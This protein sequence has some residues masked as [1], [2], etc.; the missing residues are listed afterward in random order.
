MKRLPFTLFTM[1]AL[2]V[3]LIVGL[4]AP[5]ARAAKP[6]PPDDSTPPGETVKLIF[7]HHST[8][9]N[10][11]SDPNNDQPYGGL[12]RA[13]MENNY[14][15]SATNYGWGPD[16][17]GD[18]TD[19]P[20]WPEWFTGPN[21]AAYLDALYNENGQNVGD[22]GNWPRLPSDPGGENQIVMFKSCFP[23][24]DLYGDPDDPPYPEPNGDEYSVGNAKAVYNALLPYFES[25]QDKLFIVVTAP[26]LMREETAPDRAANARAFN[27]WL[28]NDWL[29]DYAYPNVAVF[30]YYHVLTA[31][32]NHH[33]WNGD[34]VEHVQA[35][36]NNFSAYPSGD[37]HPSTA[38]H[39]KATA[40]FVPLLNVY[41]NR[42]QSSDLAPPPDASTPVPT[43]PEEPAE[44]PPET[45]DD[46]TPE[47]A[48]EPPASEP[49]TGTG[50][51]E[52]FESG[53]YWEPSSEAG[54]TI[55]CSLDN[56]DSHDGVTSLQIRYD[57]AEG[58]WGDCG[59]Y[60]EDG[61]YNWD[62]GTGVTFW[63]RA[64]NAPE[65]ATLML[66]SGPA[67]SPSPFETDV[68]I[69]TGAWTQVVIP[70]ADFALAEW[71]GESDLSSIEATSVTGYGFS[72]GPGQGS[73]WID[74]VALIDDETP[75]PST[76][77]PE[78]VDPAPA[79]P[80]EPEEPVEESGGGLCPSAALPLSLGVS[81]VLWGR[82]WGR[83][84]RLS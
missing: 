72:L 65:W 51:V 30:D 10:W 49:P 67:D 55:E 82:K 59:R 57:I 45:A 22:F 56:G 52:D 40:E 46:P 7:I 84:Q 75:P 28:V 1:F 79:E 3:G 35:T 34:G 54:S 43:K 50:V 48:D 21:S 39:Q 5:I 6:A 63:L 24:S 36:D 19:I 14:F 8:G 11:L 37:S 15:V 47:T 20:N 70:W 29:R 31:P 16:G 74:S 17:I 78:V 68:E 61:P 42:W 25:R 64:D 73:L 27:N 33:Q 76:P 60:F 13:L 83:K 71:A 53:G 4:I 66:F 44:T 2:I 26:P 12:G 77:E 23:N 32:D 18:R 9:G 38:G 69:T 81:V 62:G 41:Y 58:G 80:E